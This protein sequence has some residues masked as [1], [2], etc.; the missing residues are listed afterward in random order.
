MTQLCRNAVLGLAALC[1]CGVVATVSAC[2]VSQDPGVQRDTQ[3]QPAQK[4]PKEEQPKEQPSAP[5]AEPK[6]KEVQTEGKADQGQKTAPAPKPEVKPAQELKPAADKPDVPEATSVEGLTP[7]TTKSGLTY[8]DLKVGDGPQPASEQTKAT[9]HWSG[10]LE[11]GTLIGSSYTSGNPY[12]T[13]ID[14]VVP[15]W[16]EG[17]LSMKVGGKRRLEVPPELAYGEQGAPPRILPN[18]SL[19]FEIE[20]LKIEDPQAQR[21]LEGLT[22][23]TTDS[24]LKYYDFKVGDGEQPQQGAIV[25]LNFTGWLTDGK[26]FDTSATRQQEVKYKLAHAV[27]G[28]QEGIGSMRAGGIRRLEIPAELGFGERGAP[29]KIPPNADLIYEIELLSVIQP[30]TQTSVE[31][32]EPV[33]LESGLKYW[34][35]KVGEGTAAELGSTVEQ[36]MS[37]W[38]KDGD[39]FHSSRQL[40]RPETQRVGLFP[41]KGWNEGMVGMKPGGKRC[42][43]IPPALAFGE[44]GRPGQI[45]PNSTFIIEVDLLTVTPPIRQRSVEGIEQIVTESGLKYWDLK[46]GAGDSPGET[47]TVVVH[48]TGWLADGTI[49]DSSVERG[50]PAELKVNRVIKGWIEGLQS[51]KVGGLRRLEISPELGYGS[52]PMQAIPANST[53]IFEVELLEIKE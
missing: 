51:M 37:V 38:Y 50:Q 46:V 19:V 34:D 53:L 29:G 6:K 49:F 8:Y 23:V 11:D 44:E 16:T 41:V 47:S 22:P 12:T 13:Q 39:L 33:V 30:P 20:L 3:V 40:G 42:L 9:V 31:G 10:W 17:V 26:L 35:I 24:G 36:H 48:Y 1:V 52:R 14:G 7:V 28:W 4:A 43:E 5:Q 18:S 2:A 27:P 25:T 21:P 32:I 45:P 15:G